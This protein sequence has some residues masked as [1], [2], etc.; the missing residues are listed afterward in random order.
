ML[1]I[2]NKCFSGCNAIK[3]LYLNNF[4]TTSVINMTQM[5]YWCTTLKS[6]EINHFNTSSIR[7]MSLMFQECQHSA[8]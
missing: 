3:S 7:D 4:N 2:W 8:I 5:F 6:L 1:F